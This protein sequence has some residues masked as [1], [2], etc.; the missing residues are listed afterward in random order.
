M[1]FSFYFSSVGIFTAFRFKDRF[2]FISMGKDILRMNITKFCYCK[3]WKRNTAII[4]L[5]EHLTWF[6]LLSITS[7]STTNFLV[8]L[9]YIVRESAPYFGSWWARRGAHPTPREWKWSSSCGAGWLYG[10]RR[11]CGS[12]W[13]TI[14][15]PSRRISSSGCGATGNNEQLMCEEIASRHLVGDLP[16]KHGSRSRSGRRLKV[17][18]TGP[19][20][21]IMTALDSLRVQVAVTCTLHFYGSKTVLYAVGSSYGVKEAKAYKCKFLL[22]VY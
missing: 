15:H 2:R 16:A 10:E 22:A 14:L 7:F 19:R 5:F 1:F 13:F 21:R 6:F 17:E 11:G 8:L 9:C 18:E 20:V 4:S 12:E 3:S